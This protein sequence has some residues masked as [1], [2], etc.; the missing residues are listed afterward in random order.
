M[1]DYSFEKPKDWSVASQQS[2]VSG[3]P[4][5]QSEVRMPKL[6]DPASHENSSERVSFGD[7]GPQASMTYRV[8]PGG[9]QIPPGSPCPPGTETR[10]GACAPSEDSEAGLTPSAIKGQFKR[11]NESKDIAPKAGKIERKPPEGWR[12]VGPDVKA[13]VKEGV[14]SRIGKSK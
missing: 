4:I 6:G 5:G 7:D 11:G 8:A 9:R 10:G 2:W 12:E 13:L 3:T 1:S 14:Q